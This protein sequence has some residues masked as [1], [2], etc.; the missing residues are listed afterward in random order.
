[1]AAPLPGDKRAGYTG[2]IVGAVVVFL[3]VW[4]IVHLTNRKYEGHEGAAAAETR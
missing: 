2:L 3:I 4:G 1:M